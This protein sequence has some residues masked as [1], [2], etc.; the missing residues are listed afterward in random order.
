MTQFTYV[1]LPLP[2]TALTSCY[3]PSSP[4][5]GRRARGL[6]RRTRAL[7]MSRVAFGRA[8]QFQPRATQPDGLRNAPA[9]HECPAQ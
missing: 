8:S 4:M 7:L 9:A 3:R 6:D 2:R 5:T 1:P